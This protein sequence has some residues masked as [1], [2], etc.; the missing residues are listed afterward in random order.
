MIM[1]QKETFSRLITAVILLPL[2]LVLM[3]GGVPAMVLAL[4]FVL[5][6]AWELFL[7]VRNNRIDGLSFLLY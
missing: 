4:G 2:L 7:S 5:F 3:M 1:Y 6:M